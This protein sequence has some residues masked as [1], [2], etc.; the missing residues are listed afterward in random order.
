MLLAKE[1]RHQP[2]TLMITIITRAA[3][4]PILIRLHSQ[5][6]SFI[7]PNQSRALASFTTENLVLPVFFFLPTSSLISPPQL[8]SVCVLGFTF[9]F[10]EGKLPMQNPG[11]VLIPGLTFSPP[12]FLLAVQ[13]QCSILYTQLQRDLS[14]SLPAHQ[15]ASITC[16]FFRYRPAAPPRNCPA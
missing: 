15:L 14:I 2:L 6:S 13:S 5:C 4:G 12:A 10:S 3:S 9:S 11:S 7:L 1:Q 16:P 8:C